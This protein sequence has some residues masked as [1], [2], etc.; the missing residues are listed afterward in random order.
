MPLGAQLLL[1]QVGIVLATVLLAGAVAVQ[2]Q[3]DQIRDA[4]RQQVLAVANSTARL[5]SVVDAYG[6]PDPAAVL[7][8]RRYRSGP[9]G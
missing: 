2:H 7:R 8:R 1:L 6:S 4:Y 3:H 5:P 9:C